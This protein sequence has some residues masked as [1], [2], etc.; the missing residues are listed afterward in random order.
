MCINL[1]I[2][3]NFSKQPNLKKI[4]MCQYLNLMEQKQKVQNCFSIWTLNESN[5]NSNSS[6]KFGTASLFEL[7]RF[8]IFTNRIRT[9]ASSIPL[10]CYIYPLVCQIIHFWAN[11]KH[12]IKGCISTKW[13]PPF[14]SWKNNLLSSQLLKPLQNIVLLQKPT[15]LIF[16]YYIL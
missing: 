7:I 8:D 6:C 15:F 11:N 12:S 9:I 3:E 16:L 10:Q 14:C 4:L 2:F 13:K 1:L 5:S